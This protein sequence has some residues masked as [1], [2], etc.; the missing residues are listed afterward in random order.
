MSIRSII[1]TPTESGF[2]GRYVHHG[3]DPRTRVPLLLTLRQGRF[4]G[5][6]QAMAD[7]L[8]NAHHAGW[9]TLPTPN[10]PGGCCYCHNDFGDGPQVLTER[11]ADPLWHEAVYILHPDHLQILPAHPSGTSWQTPYR[12]PWTASPADLRL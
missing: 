11:E 4:A 2:F 7:L 10:R 6:T 3:G 12:L 1:A 5:S 8:I 9:A